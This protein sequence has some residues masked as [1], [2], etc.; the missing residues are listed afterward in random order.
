VIIL[1][2]ALGYALPT[3]L[4]AVIHAPAVAF[5]VQVFRGVATL[6]VDVLAITALQRA[7]AQD[8]LA[9][10]FGVFWAFVLAAIT[11][12]TVLTPVAVDVLGL[13]GALFVMA[14]APG[15][16]AIAGYP[17]L[18]AIDRET[19]RRALELEPRVALL[20]QLEIFAKA[21]RPILERLAAAATVMRFAPADTIIRT[22]D[23]ADALY[24]LADGEVKVTAG[25][26]GAPHTLA[27]LAAPNYFGEIGVL[28]G[29]PRTATVTALTECCCEKIDGETLREALVT[30]PP[31]SS[32]META[33]GR[34]AATQPARTLTF[35]SADSLAEE[36]TPAA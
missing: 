21:R 23:V 35:G 33:R 2:G 20:E 31:S 7:I 28:E 27:E 15:A 14:F 1:A 9:R 12:G 32:L 8:Q 10:V 25:G 16:L 36:P 30:S 11:L 24:V 18:R 6:V 5:G 19:A 29:I 13:N 17:A 22:G 4:L 3:A 26:D 34:L